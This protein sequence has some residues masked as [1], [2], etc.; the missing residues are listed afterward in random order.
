M[1][2]KM[3]K[4]D[5][6]NALLTI[7]EVSANADYVAFI[8]HELDLL[9]RKNSGDKKPTAVQLENV[10]IKDAIFSEMKV[11]QMYTVTDLIK[12]IPAVADCSNQRVSA[13]LRQMGED[14]RVVRSV[15]KR[16]TYF[17]VVK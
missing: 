15:D 16:K 14:G 12:S 3:T 2:N 10:A 11:N 8:N 9:D 6:F 1:A 17:T 5:Y 7:A 13:L 4:K